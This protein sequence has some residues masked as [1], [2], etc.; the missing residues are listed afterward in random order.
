[1]GKK[2]W[3][4]WNINIVKKNENKFH[5]MA[6]NIA[7]GIIVADNTAS[8]ISDLLYKGL[9]KRNIPQLKFGSFPH[10]YI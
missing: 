3:G 9:Q 5:C 7:G 6:Q 8:K 10:F 4:E 1:M 2:K